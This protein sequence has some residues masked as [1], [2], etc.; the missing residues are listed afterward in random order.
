MFCPDITAT[1]DGVANSPFVWLCVKLCSEFPV[2]L[3]VRNAKM[4]LIQF[5]IR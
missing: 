2:C 4:S 3:I 5:A 1:V